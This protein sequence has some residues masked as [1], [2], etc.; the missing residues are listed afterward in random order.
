MSA[1]VRRAVIVGSTVA[2]TL[3]MIAPALAEDVA[4]VLTDA[5]EATYTATRLT[6]SVWGDETQAVR[7][8]V[9]HADGAEMILV[10]ETW[11]MVGNGRRVEMG[12]SPTGLAFMTDARNEEA[13]KV[14]NG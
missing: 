13:L 11:S 10:D 12:D 4:D 1:L 14:L 3:T 5:S 6:V 2:M 9:E 8:R 7:E